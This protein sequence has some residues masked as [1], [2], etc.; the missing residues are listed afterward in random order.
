M[1]QFGYGDRH[2]KRISGKL[3]NRGLI[4]FRHAPKFG[5][6]E[7]CRKRARHDPQGSRFGGGPVF[8]S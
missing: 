8:H 5:F 3:R 4:Q 7:F 2:A 6:Y 1:E